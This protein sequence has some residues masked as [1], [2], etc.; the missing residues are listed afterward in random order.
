MDPVD[1]PCGKDEVVP[2]PI[3][4]VDWGLFSIESLEPPNDV[5]RWLRLNSK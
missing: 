5:N 2:K 1:F 4:E 3:D